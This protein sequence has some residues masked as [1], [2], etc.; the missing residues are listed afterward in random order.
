MSGAIVALAIIFVLFWIL[1]K[2]KNSSSVIVT[3]PGVLKTHDVE[4][5]FRTPAEWHGKLSQS[6]WSDGQERFTLNLR[7][8]PGRYS[9][10]VSLFYKGAHVGDFEA[11]HGKIAFSAKGMVDDGKP[12]FDIGEEVRLEF[13]GQVLTGTVEP[14]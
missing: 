4:C 8:L 5:K 12:Q 13:G 1:K 6:R 7:K 2:G 10:P 14:D 3:G 11:A 9:G